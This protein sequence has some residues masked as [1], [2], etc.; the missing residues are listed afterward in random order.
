MS[1]TN[2]NVYG[3]CPICKA[4]G[5][6]RERCPNGNDTCKNGHVYPS[7]KAIQRHIPHPSIEFLE[8]FIKELDDIK[9]KLEK[10]LEEL[11]AIFNR[12]D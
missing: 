7:A 10:N 9:V 2:I 4:H 6:S 5:V 1:D 12:N 11:K 3:F 8:N